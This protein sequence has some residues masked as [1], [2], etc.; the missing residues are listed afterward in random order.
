MHGPEN[1][2]GFFP[3]YLLQIH[4]QIGLFFL[5]NPNLKFD[6]RVGLLLVL[7]R[8]QKFHRETAANGVPN[9]NLPLSWTKLLREDT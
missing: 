6:T 8:C 3:N 2:V 5:S 7:G 9:L 1:V 4:L